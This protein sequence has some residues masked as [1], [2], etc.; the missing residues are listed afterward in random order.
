MKTVKLNYI[1]ISFV[2]LFI[3][4]G[5]SHVE[6]YE[7][8]DLPDYN[9][10][11]LTTEKPEQV[12]IAT[13]DGAKAAGKYKNITV[14]E[15]PDTVR[16]LPGYHKIVPCLITKKGVV[17]GEELTFYAQEEYTYVINHKRKW[18]KTLRF[19]IECSGVDVSS[20]L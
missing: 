13:V 1:F 9:V 10:A 5:C 6:R 2:F 14:R 18:D 20:G 8:P 3:V 12:R 19:W 11:I 7:I 15:F 4:Q 17:H 16:L